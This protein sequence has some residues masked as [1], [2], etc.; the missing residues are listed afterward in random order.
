MHSFPT[1]PLIT[2]MSRL[3]MNEWKFKKIITNSMDCLMI[4]FKSTLIIWLLFLSHNW[5][6][7]NSMCMQFLF[8]FLVWHNNNN[9]ND[10][11]WIKI[12][13]FYFFNWYYY[14]KQYFFISFLFFF[15][16]F[17]FQFYHFLFIFVC[18]SFFFH[19]FILLFFVLNT[20]YSNSCNHPVYK[21]IG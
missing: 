18:S 14:F 15:F 20:V 12:H 21:N 6:Q 13:C 19:Y 9:N 16:Y 4:P 11:I 10:Q 1:F 3:E 7:W 17:A 2:S 8:T 5:L